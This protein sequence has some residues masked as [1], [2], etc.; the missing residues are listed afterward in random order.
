MV[1]PKANKVI[2]AGVFFALLFTA[3]LLSTV[4][5]ASADGALVTRHDNACFVSGG[6]VGSPLITGDLQDV[7]TPSGNEKF[8]CQG[9]IAPGFEPK[10]TV[11]VKVSCAGF[12]GGGE[13]HVVY[14]PS[15]WMHAT[16]QIR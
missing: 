15:G 9:R 8:T 5:R 14:T 10:R 2:G 4:R 1:S 11:V 12:T 13:A 6:P 3:V 7:Q 16:C